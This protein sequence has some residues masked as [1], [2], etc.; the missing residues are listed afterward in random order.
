MNAPM[1]KSICKFNE[2]RQSRAADV[3]NWI[4]KFDVKLAI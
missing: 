2:L 1:I 3:R 4:I